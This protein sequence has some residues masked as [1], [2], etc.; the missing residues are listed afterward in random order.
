M[1]SAGGEVEVHL[2]GEQIISTGVGAE[3]EIH[4]HASYSVGA[5]YTYKWKTISDSSFQ[6]C[7]TMNKRFST[8]DYEEIVGSEQGGDI[9]IGDANNLIF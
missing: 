4:T 1:T 6:T 7:L 3:V 8:S 2:G 5:D 9:Y